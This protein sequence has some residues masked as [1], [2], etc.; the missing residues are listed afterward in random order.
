GRLIFAVLPLVPA[1]ALSQYLTFTPGRG[2]WAARATPLMILVAVMVFVLARTRSRARK[3][4]AQLDE[5][6]GLMGW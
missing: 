1:I 5:L 3:I 6:E 2:W 4:K